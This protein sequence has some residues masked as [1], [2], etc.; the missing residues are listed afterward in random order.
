MI[1][2]ASHASFATVLRFDESGILL[3]I[4]Q[5]AYYK[6]SDFLIKGNDTAYHYPKYKTGLLVYYILKAL[7]CL[8][9]GTFEAGISIDL[10]VL[11]S[12]PVLAFL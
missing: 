11:G 6:P 5:V 1:L 2:P 9:A 3:N 12:Q 10:P 8:D 4:Y 7:A